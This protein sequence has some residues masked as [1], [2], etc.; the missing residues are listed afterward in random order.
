MI[1]AGDIGGT[2]TRLALFKPSGELTILELEKYSSSEF[3]SLEEIV[4]RFLDAKKEK[5]TAACF[6]LAGPVR[7]GK[8]R[9]TNLPWEIDAEKLSKKF[10]IS[11]VAL[12]NDLYANANG[13]KIL[14][15]EELYVL[16]EGKK[17]QGNQALISAGTGL[18]EAGLFW[19]GKVHRPFA[20]EG[21]HVDFAPKNELEIQFLLFLQKKYG[22]V[23]FERAVSGPAIYQIY[24]FLLESKRISRS[25][26]IEEEMKKQ[27]P[28]SVI[29]EY[30]R[31]HKDK[32]CM[33]AL[34]LFLSLYG[35]EAGNIALKFL[36]IGG[37]YIGGGIAPR[38][39]E[40]FKQSP[41]LSSF[42][43]KGRFKEFLNSIPI[44]IVL[45]D[46]TALLGAASFARGD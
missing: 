23:S 30:A 13:L 24:L 3:S 42:S 6:A 4:V 11:S 1:L 22:H 34:M 26:M 39:L 40:M 29:S 12:L 36:A 25:P 14:K 43:N 20:S 19:D 44:S 2:H 21:G 10:Q 35:S 31:I 27:D 15:P 46:N 37:V 7:D 38:L 32:G 17:K 5:V 45:N 18:G 33:E 8:C 9:I 41:F 28:S 16:H